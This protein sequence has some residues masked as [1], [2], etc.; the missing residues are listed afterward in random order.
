MLVIAAAALLTVPAVADQSGGTMSSGSVGMGSDHSAGNA[1]S[2][3]NMQWGCGTTGIYRGTSGSDLSR[4]TPKDSGRAA[5][6]QSSTEQTRSGKS[7]Q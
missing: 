6:A 4:A 2:A 7:G 1:T 5:Q 3:P